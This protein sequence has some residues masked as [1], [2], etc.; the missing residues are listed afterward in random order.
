LGG[1]RPVAVGPTPVR[2]HA[3][4]SAPDERVASSATPVSARVPY[5]TWA[6][7]AHASRLRPMRLVA[8]PSQEL[9]LR[10]LT[11]ADTREAY[12]ARQ[13]EVAVWTVFLFERVQ[14]FTDDLGLAL[15]PALRE[16]CQPSSVVI[17]QID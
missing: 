17:R 9:F 12:D 8:E 16:S 2:A 7:Y 5:E 11:G 15:A 4:A 10:N 13:C 14:P 6:R 3:R 1:G